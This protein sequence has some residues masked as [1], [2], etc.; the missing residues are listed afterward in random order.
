VRDLISKLLVTDPEKRYSVTQ[1]FSHPW[2]RKHRKALES[3]YDKMLAKSLASKVP[4]EA[5]E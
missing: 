1:M 2:I 5:N 4:N 3:M